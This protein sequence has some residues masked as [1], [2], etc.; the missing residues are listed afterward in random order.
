MLNVSPFLKGE[1]CPHGQLYLPYLT[2]TAHYWSVGKLIKIPTKT[3][4]K[5]FENF[6]LTPIFQK[7]TQKKWPNKSVSESV[8]NVNQNVPK[9][10]KIYT[11]ENYNDDLTET[12]DRVRWE[13]MRLWGNEWPT[14][15]NNS[16]LSFSYFLR[17]FLFLFSI[18]NYEVTR[19][20]GARWAQNF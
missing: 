7:V 11:D 19:S 13:L 10:T 20:F 14:T 3:S 9:N 1:M 18:I 17:F 6:W 8:N 16:L 2:S 5:G 12:V 4:N 15:V